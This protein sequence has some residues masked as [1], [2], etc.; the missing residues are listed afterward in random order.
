LFNRFLFNCLL[1]RGNA[2]RQEKRS[3]REQNREKRRAFHDH[4]K[5]PLF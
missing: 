4:I 5:Q 1:A 2:A 3:G